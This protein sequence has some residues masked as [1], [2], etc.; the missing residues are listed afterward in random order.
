MHNLKTSAPE[1]HQ[2]DSASN[3]IIEETSHPASSIYMVEQ[4]A[5][6]LVSANKIDGQVFDDVKEIDIAIKKSILTISD[7]PSRCVAE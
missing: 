7:K 2:D 3:G 4:Q 5:S 6:S 1:N